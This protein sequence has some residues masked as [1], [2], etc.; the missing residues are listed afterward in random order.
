MARAL[1][2]TIIRAMTE[3]SPNL[4]F[5]ALLELNHSTGNVR[6][7]NDQVPLRPVIAEPPYQPFPFRVTLPTDDG[8]SMPV[9]NVT[10][11]N[12]DQRVSIFARRIAG[13]AVPATCTLAIVDHA[14]PNVKLLEYPD[15]EIHSL[16]YSTTELSFELH[17]HSSL[18]EFFG[19][20]RFTP[21]SF[22]SL[23]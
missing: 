10:V 12:V 23:F 22:P 14:N 16:E 11:M 5:L 2:Q 17:S 1:P 15:F 13:N 3:E 20:Y 6:I 21:G 7:V 9:L 18:N 4:V 19:A 8:E